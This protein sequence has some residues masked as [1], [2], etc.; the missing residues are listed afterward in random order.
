MSTESF[1]SSHRPESSPEAPEHSAEQT[2]ERTGDN[3]GNFLRDG[4]DQL[5][6]TLRSIAAEHGPEGVQSYLHDLL[7]TGGDNAPQAERAAAFTLLE[8]RQKHALREQVVE[9]GVHMN[10]LLERGVKDG[11]KGIGQ[12]ARKLNHF[13]EQFHDAMSRPQFE[14]QAV[15]AAANTVKAIDGLTA[16]RA[17]WADNQRTITADFDN[18]LS[19][20]MNREAA[21]RTGKELLDP[22]HIGEAMDLSELFDESVVA[23]AASELHQT[24]T[25]PDSDPQ[26]NPVLSELEADEDEALLQRIETYANFTSDYSRL[27]SRISHDQELA[28]ARHH[29]AFDAFSKSRGNQRNS[30]DVNALITETRNLPHKTNSALGSADGMRKKLLH[31]LASI[32][33]EAHTDAEPASEPITEPTRLPR[34]DAK[35]YS[36][37]SQTEY[38]GP[39]VADTEAIPS[40]SASFAIEAAPAPTS[41]RD[42]ERSE[43]SVY[44]MTGI[45]ETYATVPAAE[46]PS[47]PTEIAPESNQS[48]VYSGLGVG[49]RMIINPRVAEQAAESPSEQPQPKEPEPSPYY[50]GYTYRRQDQQAPPESEKSYKAQS[51]FDMGQ[52]EAFIRRPTQ[53]QRSEAVRRSYAQQEPRISRPENIPPQGPR[54]KRP[55][56]RTF[57]QADQLYPLTSDVIEQI[58][59]NQQQEAAQ[60]LNT[61]TRVN[62]R[63]RRPSREERFYESRVGRFLINVGSRAIRASRFLR[64]SR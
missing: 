54:I 51:G 29:A 46:M 64:R 23:Q 37:G 34:R 28:G 27:L 11:R 55:E 62:D 20:A 56:T 10:E 40:P 24:L 1:P 25:S 41:V 14:S 48:S 60:W 42:P 36:G 30:R 47:E 7:A 13:T 58:K 9:S 18:T 8:K 31:D 2:A 38:I 50:A 12:H 21:L 19:A 61:V 3:S 59:L 17:S 6:N 44:S 53:E 5:T 39:E 32:S 4:S 16:H 22:Q 26:Q 33:D 35:P 49:D 52:T 45:R 57:E 43:S 15:P 63:N